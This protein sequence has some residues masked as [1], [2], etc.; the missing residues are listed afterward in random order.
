MAIAFTLIFLAAVAGIIKPYIGNLRRGHF[1]LA[2]VVAFVLVGVTGPTVE[3]SAKKVSEAKGDSPTASTEASA[4]QS[5]QPS[6]PVAP[7]PAATKW[8]YS[9]DRD[10]MRGETT[11]YAVLN[12]D[13]EVDLDFP[14][15]VQSGT[16]TIRGR[17][18]D[19]L[20][21]MFSVGKGQ[22]LCSNFRDS[23]L[24][25]KF[26]GGGIQRFACT[27][28]SDGSSETAFITSEAKFLAQLRKA[29][30]TIIEAEFYQKGRQQ[31]VFET[32]NLT[33]K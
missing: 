28:T 32:A 23:H 10:E 20:N 24:S 27:G 6:A 29:K 25:A 17:P 9:E 3:P 33:W 14:Y 8:E 30:R 26:D 15:G 5:S 22:I 7:T 16:L 31:F 21:V 12:S 4:P 13:N 2:A 19:G 11:K 1:A 18:Q